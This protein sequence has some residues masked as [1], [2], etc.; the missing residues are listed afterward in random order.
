M[1]S[2]YRQIGIRVSFFPSFS[3]AYYSCLFCSNVNRTQG[4]ASTKWKE[5]RF[6]PIAPHTL[7]IPV[8]NNFTGSSHSW[9]SNGETAIKINQIRV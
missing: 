8:A 2:A 4:I 1:P 9:D 6:V 5:R 3:T 7:D